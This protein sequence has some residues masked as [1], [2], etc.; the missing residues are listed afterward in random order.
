MSKLILVRHGNTTGNSA[1]RFWGSTDVELSAEGI[2]QAKRLHERLAAE[3][4]DFIYASPLSRTRLT[5][6][7][8][9]EGRDMEINT[10]ADLR[11][12]DFGEVEGLTYEEIVG[13]YPEM[14][15]ALAKWS[16]KPSFP[17]GESLEDMDVRVRSFLANLDGHSSED[18]ILIVSHAGALRLMICNLLGISLD[19]WRHLQLDLASLSVLD[20]YPQGAII[21]SLN[22]T[23]HLK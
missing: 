5:A 4:I 21:K 7:I 16:P 23:A 14:A 6:E 3:S 17:G 2:G 10:S 13:K 22:D 1:M 18:T 15:E 20:T 11:E 8:I 12:I 19:H 9:A